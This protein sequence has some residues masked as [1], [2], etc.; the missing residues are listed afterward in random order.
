[1]KTLHKPEFKVGPLT[2]LLIISFLLLAGCDNKPAPQYHPAPGVMVTKASTQMVSETFEFIGRTEAVNDVELRARVQGYLLE[3]NFVEGD[4]IEL[5][6][7]LFTIESD[8]YESEVAAAQGN[9]ERAEAEV[10]RTVDD[11]KRYEKLYKTQNVSERDINKARIS[12]TRLSNRLGISRTTLHLMF[13]HEIGM[14]K[15]YALAIGAVL[16]EV[17]NE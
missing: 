11:L 17:G 12:Q 16:Q 5:G 4:N 8:T 6:D 14:R 1:M 10:A 7:I 13:K 15:V 3:R 9:V 2:L